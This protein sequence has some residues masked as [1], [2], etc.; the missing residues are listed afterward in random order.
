MHDERSIE[1]TAN[2]QAGALA[3]HATCH[4]RCLHCR[5]P[6]ALNTITLSSLDCYNIL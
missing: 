3:G 5:R 1:Y 2:P 6:N 4:P